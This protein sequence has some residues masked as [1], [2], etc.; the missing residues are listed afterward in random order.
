MVA[1]PFQQKEDDT[2]K[3]ILTLLALPEQM[4]IN[5]N[6]KD[7]VTSYWAKHHI[8]ASKSLFGEVSGYWIEDSSE[9]PDGSLVVGVVVEFSNQIRTAYVRTG[10]PSWCSGQGDTYPNCTCFDAGVCYQRRLWTRFNGSF[11]Y[12]D[13]VFNKTTLAEAKSDPGNPVS[14]NDPTASGSCGGFTW[15]HLV[16]R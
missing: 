7:G 9:N 10:V 12:C 11:Y 3:D 6:W 13:T 8:G 2:E 4:E 5:G 1:C 15:T 14:Y 16:P